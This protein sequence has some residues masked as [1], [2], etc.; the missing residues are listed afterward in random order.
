MKSQA[1]I[2]ESARGRDYYLVAAVVAH[3]DVDALRRLSRSFCMPG[4]RRWH[5]VNERESRRRQI[6]ESLV[7][8]NQVQVGIALGSGRDALVRA[9]GLRR[10]AGMLLDCEVTRLLIESREGRDHLDREI[11]IEEL[12]GHQT[13]FD[14]A[15]L[16]PHAEPLLWVA[17]AFAWCA[18]AGGVWRSRIAPA[19]LH[20]WE[21]NAA[22]S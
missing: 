12:R 18:S 9:E 15:H 2:D 17:D 13:P 5:F 21:V 8:T 6:L 1:F 14:Y 7:A 11:L 10:I 19:I 3:G 22:G 16:P 4:Q 20:T